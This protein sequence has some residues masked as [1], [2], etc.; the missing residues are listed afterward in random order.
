MNY[1]TAAKKRPK[2]RLSR[3]VASIYLI[4]ALPAVLMLAWLGV[5]FGFALR[6][7]AQAK[8]AADAIALAAAARYPDGAAA[9]LNDALLAA[10]SNRGPNGPVQIIL[11]DGAGLGGDLRFG[12]WD[13]ETRQ[14]NPNPD[15]GAAVWVRV[16]FAADHPNGPLRLLLAG[17]FAN[18]PYAI[19]RHS[20]AVHRPSRHTTSL[21]V[22]GRG[23]SMLQ[24]AG[25]AELYSD[26]GLAV[27][28]PNAAAVV[29]AGSA[30]VKSP[31]VR[32]A[33]D[34]SE[35]SQ[36]GIQ[37]RALT[38]ADVPEDPKGSTALPVWSP[39]PADSITH[40]GVT[41]TRVAPG[42]HVGLVASGGTVVLE[43]GLH[44]FSGPIVL[45]GTAEL[46]L[47]DAVIH[48]AG[49]VALQLSGSSRITGTPGV[50][51]SDWGRCWVLQRATPAAWEIHDAA[52]VLV[53]G[54]LYAPKTSIDLDGTA[55]LTTGAAVVQSLDLAGLVQLGLTGRLQELDLPAE[56][57]RAR[58]VR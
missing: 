33:G 4:I 46:Q 50:D 40:D 6:A 20:V 28:S 41:V 5:E 11:P 43:A 57:G 8:T 18:G 56:P 54:R 13:E 19:E 9:V 42:L 12:E 47:E 2:A 3:G 27:A 49:G 29:V 16:R 58:L 53:Q 38:S 52:Q 26:A 32:I 21:L 51:V 25:S 31:V 23:P 36:T 17:L 45:S 35:S 48:L 44:Q 39:A 1:R 30:V 14:F 7:Y 34:L 55:Q 15:G 10:A 24:L 37:G 22:V